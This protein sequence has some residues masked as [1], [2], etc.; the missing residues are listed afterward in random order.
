MNP[1]PSSRLVFLSDLK[2]TRAGEKVR[3]LGCVECYD[4]C[5]ATLTLKH[6]YP[7]NPS[8]IAHVNIEHVL[9]SVNRDDLE[10]GAWLNIIGTVAPPTTSA[11][12]RSK[13]TQRETAAD[14]V[15]VLAT[16]LWNAGDIQL[17]AY[18][19]AVEARKAADALFDRA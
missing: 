7:A 6:A 9:E 8:T 1:L 10:I 13:M 3:F 18:E 14:S 16:L 5:T 11:K 2:R 15:H 12:Q 19:K 17:D 4:V